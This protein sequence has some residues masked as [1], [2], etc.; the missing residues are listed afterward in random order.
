MKIAY[1]SEGE[2]AW[3]YRARDAPLSGFPRIRVVHARDM[4]IDV[5]LTN[6]VSP[7]NVGFA[8]SYALSGLTDHFLKHLSC[9]VGGGDLTWEIDAGTLH[10]VV[11]FKS[12]VETKPID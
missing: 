10:S 7:I 2:E 4:S 5:Q 9:S 6:V 11:R 12:N 8:L 3:K 1:C